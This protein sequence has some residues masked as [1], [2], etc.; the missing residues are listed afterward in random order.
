MSTEDIAREARAWEAQLRA[1]GL[2]PMDAYR[3]AHREAAWQGWALAER[4]AALDPARWHEPDSPDAREDPAVL[5]AQAETLIAEAR[6]CFEAAQRQT[7]AETITWARPP[8]A[9]EPEPHAPEA[10][11]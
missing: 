1:Q 3:I 6:P 7:F 9:P 8:Q 2:R 5:Q 11:L 4:Q 10:S